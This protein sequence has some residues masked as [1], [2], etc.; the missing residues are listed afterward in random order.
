MS[1]TAVPPNSRWFLLYRRWLTVGFVAYWVVMFTLTHLPDP[2]ELFTKGFDDKQ[3]H[4]LGYLLFGIGLG[5]MWGVW[6]GRLGWLPLLGLFA[7]AITYAA[8]DEATQPWFQRY[9]DIHDWYSDVRGSGLGLGLAA[10]Y[11][12]ASRW[13]AGRV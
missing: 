13:L 12:R 5:V 10:V 6:R 3:A 11:D 9:A 1:A 7:L 8:C 2:P 4:G